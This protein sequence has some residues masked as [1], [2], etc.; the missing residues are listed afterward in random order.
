MEQYCGAE[1]VVTIE[2]DRVVKT[3]LPKA[4]RL[5]ALDAALRKQRSRREAR[6]LRKLQGV[7]RVPAVLDE[8]VDT[9]VLERIHGEPLKGHI[10]PARCRHAGQLVGKMHA[11]RIIHGDL[12]TSNLMVEHGAGKKLSKGPKETEKTDEAEQIA[13][14]DFGLSYPSHKL[15][16]MA[17]DV[18]V[19]EQLVPA[20]CFDAFWKGY[21]KNQPQA[22]DVQ[23]RLEKLKNRGRYKNK[24]G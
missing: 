22:A 17:T 5:P 10:T 6:I 14:V 21:G 20:A 8:N 13:L 16:D 2:K 4:Y 12:T 23:K 24:S 3:R 18:H 1:A 15:E 19:F 11:A 9:L 7:I